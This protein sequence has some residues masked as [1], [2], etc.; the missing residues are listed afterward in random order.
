MAEEIFKVIISDQVEDDLVEI[1]EYYQSV[2]KDAEIAI[3]IAEKIENIIKELYF[4]P[5]R[6]SNLRNK[7]N[8]ET[9]LKYIRVYNWDIIYRIIKQEVHIKAI[10]HEKRE[11]L[12]FTF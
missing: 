7:I 8:T 3:G 6:G 11:F 4:M 9:D 12:H 10:V 1:F 5:E 2:S